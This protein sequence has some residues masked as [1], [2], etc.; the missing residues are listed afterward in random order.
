MTPHDHWEYVEGCYRC[1]ISRDEEEQERRE[2]AEF[3]DGEAMR[4]AEAYQA[5]CEYRASRLAATDADRS[6]T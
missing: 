3:L 5:A 4:E 2:Y 1:E 6:E